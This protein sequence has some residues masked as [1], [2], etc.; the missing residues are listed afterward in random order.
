[1]FQV[2]MVI[3]IPIIW[4]LVLWCMVSLNGPK[5]FEFIKDMVWAVFCLAFLCFSLAAFCASIIYL[6]KMVP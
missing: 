3:L 6:L 2:L 1:M 5:I 4:V